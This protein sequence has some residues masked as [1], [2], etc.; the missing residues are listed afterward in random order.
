[1]KYAEYQTKVEKVLSELRDG[2][3]DCDYASIAV[4]ALEN[5]Y[6]RGIEDPIDPEC[7]VQ[8]YVELPEEELK[9]HYKA[10]KEALFRR[11]K[12]VD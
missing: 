8:E 1:M 10:C 7:L 11:L 3:V 2:A 6:D 12:E 5:I 9:V 4:R